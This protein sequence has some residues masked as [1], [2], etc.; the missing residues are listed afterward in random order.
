MK[1][2]AII[3]TGLQCGHTI[4][5]PSGITLPDEIPVTR[6]FDKEVIGRASN[7]T[8]E[9]GAIHAIIDVDDG[10]GLASAISGQV[11]ES[12]MKDGVRII[13]KFDLRVVGLV[14][15]NQTDTETLG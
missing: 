5:D 7:F 15:P 2:K 10:I 14:S 3:H 8:L 6:G 13:D 12:R 1:Y 11:V 4:I 9:H